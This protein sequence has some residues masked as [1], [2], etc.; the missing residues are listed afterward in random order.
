MMKRIRSQQNTATLNQN[1]I[2]RRFFY[3]VFTAFLLIGGLYVYFLGS[4]VFS[5]LERKTVETEVASLAQNVNDLE[6]SYLKEDNSINLTLATSLG[7]TEAK[8]ALFANRT[9]LAQSVSLR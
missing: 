1:D 3:G 2:N 4:I 9:A 5:V 8:G 6:I 7:F